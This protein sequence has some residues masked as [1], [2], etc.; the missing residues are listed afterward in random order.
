MQSKQF[1]QY[2]I[3]IILIA[4]VEASE[5]TEDLEGRLGHSENTAKASRGEGEEEEDGW[6]VRVMRIYQL[7]DNWE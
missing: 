5:R 2:I 7:K 3:H 6:K 4:T 1:A